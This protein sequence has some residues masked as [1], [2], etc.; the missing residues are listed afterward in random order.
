MDQKS[1]KNGT[2]NWW[3]NP[4]YSN[5]MRGNEIKITNP[6]NTGYEIKIGMVHLLFLEILNNTLSRESCDKT[7]YSFSGIS[8]LEARICINTFNTLCKLFKKGGYLY[9]LQNYFKDEILGL[10][11][12]CILVI[13][14]SLPLS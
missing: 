4:Q 12:T 3:D 1:K 10:R 14:I 7:F 13:L 11:S 6:S 9:M 5:F 8:Y 2:F